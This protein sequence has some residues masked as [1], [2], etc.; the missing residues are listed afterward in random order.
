MKEGFVVPA[1]EKFAYGIGDFAINISYGAINLYFFFFLTNSASI[2]PAWAG[3]IILIA[4]FWDAITDYFVG[5]LS[6]KTVSRFGKRRPYILFG[7]LPFGILF[8]LLWIIPFEN[9]THLILYYLSM[10]V[11]FNIAFTIVA[12]PYNSMLPELTQNYDERTSIAGY[13]MGLSFVGTLL[14]AAGT[15]V[16]VDI[17]FGGKKAYG[18]SFPVAGLVFGIIISLSLMVT[19]F[20]TKERVYSSGTSNHEGLIKTFKSIMKL[21]EFRIILGMYLFNM[22]GFDL[23]QVILIFF[24]KDVINVPEADSFIFMAIPLVI[25]VLCAPLWI[26]LGEKWGKKKAYIVAAIYM[27]ISFLFC[28]LA[29]EGNMNYMYV[30]CAFAGIG[31]SASQVIPYSIIPDVIEV[32]EYENGTR[33]EGAFYGVIMFLYKAAS[34]LTIE[35]TAIL[36]AVFGYIESKAGAAAVDQPDSAI[37]AI[38]ILMGVGPGIFFL[39]SAIFVHRLPITKERFDEIRGIIDERRKAE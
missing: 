14:A 23:I 7:C 21:R 32:D 15:M 33:R 19:F 10:M 22:I 6:D 37:W 39:I 25:A 3:G 8:A 12:V 16:I 13:K 29:P 2:S 28:L 4:R 24:L 36:L 5:M 9:Q 18:T 17:L 30:I 11:L 31:I 35:A 38:R 27:S 1:R 34:A 20:G 26:T